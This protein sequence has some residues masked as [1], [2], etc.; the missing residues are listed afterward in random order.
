MKARRLTV[1]LAALSLVV[2]LG[3]TA[4][5]TSD[6][7]PSP[8][9]PTQVL[10]EFVPELMELPAP[11]WLMTGYRF[12]YD[13]YNYDKED[14]IISSETLIIDTVGKG[15]TYML[16]EIYMA[17]F[18]EAGELI[19]FEQVD[20][21]VDY[22]GVGEFWISLDA[23]RGKDAP[24]TRDDIFTVEEFTWEETTKDAWYAYLMS[25]DGNTDYEYFFDM[26][27]GLLLS[28]DTYSYDEQGNY[29][30]G[31]AMKY[32]DYYEYSAPWL[33]YGLMEL[34]EGVE[35][36]YDM[37]IT[38]TDGTVSKGTMSFKSAENH[39]T[40]VDMI[41]T[42]KSEDLGDSDGFQF[43]SEMCTDGLIMW[44]P[45][46]GLKAVKEGDYYFQDDIT[47]SF[48]YAGGVETVEGLGDARVIS[49]KNG[50]FEADSYFRQKDGALIRYYQYPSEEKPFKLV[51]TLKE[52]K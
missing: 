52:I 36:V 37:R 15:G 31:S 18:G 6:P 20:Y 28:L 32:Y 49:F 13:I 33:D 8:S 14:N 10:T 43:I 17:S 45:L 5:A 29:L 22:N 4:T 27:D 11:Q 25:A 47:G 21:V 24:A 30:G 39:A 2:A 50:Y 7:L 23:F 16:S 34:A 12:F 38:M 3:L 35:L 19:S 48:V 46:E 41:Q 9:L 42:L 51:I 40:W 44:L 26:E 1:L